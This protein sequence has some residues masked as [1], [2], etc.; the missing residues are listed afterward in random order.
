[1]PYI[2]RHRRQNY[3]PYLSELKENMRWN[4]KK[5]DLTYLVYSLALSSFYR[6]KSYTTI[7]NAISSL[8]D[9]AEEI[10][11]RHLNGYEDKKIQENGDIEP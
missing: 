9:A 11:R 6:N 2:E 1:M 3:E 10:R 8:I 4:E 7:S 5:G